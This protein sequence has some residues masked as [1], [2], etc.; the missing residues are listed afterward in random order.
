[1]IERDTWPAYQRLLADDPAGTLALVAVPIEE[2]VGQFRLSR[3]LGMILEAL[4]THGGI[5]FERLP[6]GRRLGVSSA[7]ITVEVTIDLT[8]PPTRASAGLPADGDN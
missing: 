4:L 1:L 5:H 2:R 6:R 3:R 8:S 7:V